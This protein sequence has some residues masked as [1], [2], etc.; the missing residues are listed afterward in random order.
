VVRKKIH[1]RINLLLI[2]TAASLLA[3]VVATSFSA[4]KQPGFEV[5][6]AKLRREALANRISQATLDEALSDIDLIPRVIELDRNQPEFTLT[7]DKYLNRVV[8]E[9]RIAKGREKLAEN[10]T[11]LVEV[12]RQYGVQPCNLVALWGIETDFGRYKERFPVIGALATLAYEG[13]RSDF[14]RKELLYALRILEGGHISVRKMTGSWAGAMGQLQFMPSTFHNFALDYDGDERI[15]IWNNLGDAF[16]SGA[17]YLAKSGWVK[18]QIW[19]REVRLPKGFDQTL[20]GLKKRKRLSEWQ[21]LGVRRPG[22]RDLPKKPDLLASVLEPDGK[23]GRAFL[24]YNNYR[25]IL[26]WNRSHF[27]GIA[28]GTLADRIK[29]R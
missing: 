6:L 5:W 24:V 8:T 7:L 11:L 10:R 16:A 9:S 14:F 4:E 21:A 26:N 3:P 19:G 2:L 20:L 22:D 27:F 23:K 25:V 17:N 13:R 18:D 29:G 28:V 15:D 12:F 1:L